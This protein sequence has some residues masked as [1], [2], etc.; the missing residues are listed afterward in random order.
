MMRSLFRPLSRV[1]ARQF[2]NSSTRKAA[3]AVEVA[4]ED[5]ADKELAAHIAEHQAEFA[6]KPAHGTV[7]YNWGMYPFYGL[8]GTT[9]LSK[10]LFI[11]DDNFPAVLMFGSVFLFFTWVG[12]PA[13]NGAI[14]AQIL[15]AEQKKHDDFELIFAL[16]DRTTDQIKAFNKQPAMLK[17]YLAEYKATVTELSEA[18]VRKLQLDAYNNTVS[19]L[20]AIASQKAAEG[21]AQANVA[22][23]VLTEF[24]S[25]AFSDAK[26]VDASIEEAIDNLSATTA[27]DPTGEPDSIV[28]GIFTEYIQSGQFDVERIARLEQ[29]KAEEAEKN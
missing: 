14:N 15:E 28:S 12:G 20:Q 25:Q 13:I 3:A 1:Q 8:L 18:E 17:E 27:T 26:I 16:M 23:D 24:M 11:L 7:L 22:D 6:G 5:D 21:A 9:V 19:Q 2:W 29:I 10:E 4:V